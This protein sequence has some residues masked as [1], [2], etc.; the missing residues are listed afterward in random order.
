MQ[1]PSDATP[2][3]ILLQRASE[4]VQMGRDIP[5]GARLRILKRLI[6]R[7]ARV[8]TA[9][10]IVFNQTSVSLLQQLSREIDSQ[11]D[12]QAQALVRIENNET[13]TRALS[14]QMMDV[15][16]Q[17]ALFRSELTL[18][19]AR[20]GESSP[21]GDASAPPSYG[22]DRFTAMYA[23][24][25]QQFRGSTEEIRG[26]QQ[27]YIPDVLQEPRDRGPVLDIGSGRGE[28]LTLLKEHE[29]PAYGVDSNEN[30]VDISI[31]AG[32]DVR[33]GDAV[34][35][36]KLLP[37][38][39]LS[40][41]T[42]FHVAEHLPFSVLL[43]LIDHSLRT[44]IPGGLLILET[45]NPTNLIVGAANFYLDPTHNKPLH[46]RLLHF[47]IE[48]RGFTKV[49]TRFLAPMEVPEEEDEQAYLGSSYYDY[50]ILGVRPPEVDGG[51]S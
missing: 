18:F 6:N 43:D 15:M 11:S 49:E 17:N 2:R 9:E 14:I 24:F 8:F 44:L 34:M 51:R 27:A 26:R 5:T 20:L 35:H 21:T 33:L 47:L 30:F 1:E 37:D 45:P 3:H 7:I 19:R 32:L 4:R 42:A 29:I 48:A 13:E 28:W 50:A 16:A 40:T 25:E 38:A 12:T 41:I 46:P 22:D 36:L 10:Q 31:K 39:A 23:A